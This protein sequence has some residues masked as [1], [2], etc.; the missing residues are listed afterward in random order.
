[1]AEKG[2]YLFFAT[3]L[4]VLEAKKQCQEVWDLF[5]GGVFSGG[6]HVILLEK[7]TRRESKHIKIK[8]ELQFAVKDD[9][10]FALKEKE[11]ELH[12]HL[13]TDKKNDRINK[14]TLVRP[15]KM[16]WK[17][18]EVKLIW[19]FLSQDSKK[20]I[21]YF[22]E[23]NCLQFVSAQADK[24]NGV[25]RLCEWMG[26][27]LSETAAAGDAQEDR[28]MLNICGISIHSF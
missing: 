3:S 24:A 21:R 28:E 10:L 8:K 25:R 4:P 7:E 2:V 23:E 6:G 12:F 26:I 14:I 1:M 22:A 17:E 15:K 27:S 16:P 18:E 5:Y 19:E 13:I 20:D 11:G 9:L